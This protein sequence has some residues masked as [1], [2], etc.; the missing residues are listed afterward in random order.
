MSLQALLLT[1]ECVIY[2]HVRSGPPTATPWYIFKKDW[3]SFKCIARQQ[4]RPTSEDLELAFYNASAAESPITKGIKA[5]RGF[6]G[7]KS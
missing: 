1:T 7:K 6:T 2:K 5:V 4:R 3:A